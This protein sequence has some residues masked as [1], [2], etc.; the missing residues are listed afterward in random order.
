VVVVG[1]HLFGAASLA[2]PEGAAVVHGTATFQQS[3]NYTAIQASDRAI[4]NYQSFDIAR[5]ETVEFMQPGASA[6]VLNRILSANPTQI[7]GTLLANGRV[8]FVNPA[9][10][11]FGGSA[12]VNVAQLIA[13]GLDI[14]DADFING[15]YDFKGGEG[16]VINHGRISAERAYLIGKQVANL[17]TIDCPGGYVVLAAGDRV[18]LGEPGTD[19][20]VEMDEPAPPD[21][22]EPIEGAA[23]LNEGSVDAAG[24]E[25]VLA[26]AGDIYAHAI[27][28]VGKLSA[29]A[30][31]GDAGTVK[32]AAPEGTVINTGSIEAVGESGQGGDVRMLGDRVGVFGAGRIDASGA[33]GGGSILV[34]G[35]YQ[36]K[37]EVPTASRTSVGAGASLQADATGNGDGGKIIVWSDETTKFHGHASAT[38]AG[39]GD[40]GLIEVSGKQ[41]LNFGGTAALGSPGGRG[42]T[43]LLDPGWIGITSGGEA[44]PPQDDL[45]FND[46]PY[47]ATISEWTLENT[48]V[49]SNAEIVLEATN[50]IAIGDLADDALTLSPGVS[51][52]LRTRNNPA[53]EENSDGGIQIAYGD[54]VVAS[55]GGSI[56]L[57]A[58]HDG[59]GFVE[60]STAY[61]S[62]GSFVTDGG[63]VTIQATGSIFIEDVTTSGA[64]NAA[65][66]DVVLEA[67]RLT[68]SHN[69]GVGT[70]DTSG[71][72]DAD[73]SGA[74]AAGSVTVSAGGA[75]YVR[76]IL[77][78]G[79]NDNGNNAPGGAGGPVTLGAAEEIS[80]EGSS[81]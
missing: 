12:Q 20:L 76:D 31:K 52:V 13:S 75:V 59:Q 6:S 25:I 40:G 53:F 49:G 18:F 55:G 78:V 57:Q 80:W 81:I 62:G 38:G 39:E 17:G 58:G 69:L 46:E 14:S 28:N 4:I 79:G 63:S 21:R 15:R 66:G 61:V 74:N 1:L 70:I 9:G 16:S 30:A 41:N 11:L 34:G 24:G 35:D 29:S 77:A 71:G 47:Q 44:G 23:V 8:F 42:G 19:L 48:A 45:A 32:L 37:G 5:P 68:A 60:G 33:A 50:D 26:A 54:S 3:G 64:A 72:A 51:L 2:G 56:T 22:S 43:L 73:A 67:G 7:D 65:G 36:G 27:S 10:V